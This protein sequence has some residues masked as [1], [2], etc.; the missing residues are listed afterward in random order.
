MKW[1]F[2]GLLALAGL[3]I[4]LV[5]GFVAINWQSDIPLEA[6]TDRWAQP[7]SEFINV[8]GNRLVAHMQLV[9]LCHSTEVVELFDEFDKVL[10]ASVLLGDLYGA[11]KF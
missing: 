1:I 9:G 8:D 7:P 10:R 4:V 6:L 5:A 3:V 11:E 2:R